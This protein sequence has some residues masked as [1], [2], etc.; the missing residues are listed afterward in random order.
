MTKITVFED[1][2][3]WQESKSLCSEL[4]R[5]TQDLKDYSFKDQLLRATV[6]IMNN[7][8]E[9]YE[10]AGNREF[11]RF[12]YIAKGSSAE[13]RSLLALGKEIGY[14]NPELYTELNQ[15]VLVISK[16]LSALIKTL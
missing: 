1:M 2:T 11:K 5:L 8:A 12:L 14:F 9:G 3:V 7:I 15:S 16:R 6:S 4:Y 13:V 10:R